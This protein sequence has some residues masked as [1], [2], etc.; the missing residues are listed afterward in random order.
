MSLQCSPPLNTCMDIHRCNPSASSGYYQIQ[1][2]NGSLEQVYC[3]MEG[4]NCGGEGGW[5]RM[6][7]L[8]MADPSSQCPAG[9]S[10]TTQNGVRFC[11]RSNTAAGCTGID[12]DNF[13]HDY[14]QVCGFVR[15]YAYHTPDAFGP[16]GRSSEPLSGNYVDGVSITYGTPPNHLWTYAAGLTEEGG[17]ISTT[18][19]CPCNTD[20]VKSNVP[21]YVGSDYYCESGALNNFSQ[22]W[23]TDDPL[24][25]GMQCGGTEGPCCANPTPWFNRNMLSPTNDDILMRVCLN[26]DAGNENIGLERVEIY[27]K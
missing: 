22:Q 24:W 1:T 14:T 7:R 20:G 19:A 8:S 2:A 23:Y 9:F 5:T 10:L 26:E 11:T 17:S 18:F 16:L 13:G 6:F 15:G 21:S 25:D 3:D 12:T 27:V 4:A